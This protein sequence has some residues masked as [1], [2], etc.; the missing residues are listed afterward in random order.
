MPRSVLELFNEIKAETGSSQTARWIVAEAIS[1]PYYQALSLGL[2]VQD[3]SIAKAKGFVERLQ[4]GEPIQYV[5]GRWGFRDLELIVDSRA[6]IPRPE[7]EV[8]VEMAIRYLSRKALEHPRVLELGT[9]SGACAIAIATEVKGSYVLATDLSTEA[10]SLATTNLEAHKGRISGQVELLR[11]DW[12][13]AVD[14]AEQ[15]MIESGRFDL[16]LSNP[17]YINQVDYDHLD[18]VVRNW[19]PK[20]AL[21]SGK[22]GT[23]QLETILEKAPRYLN[24]GASVVLEMD[25]SQVEKVAEFARSVGYQCEIF[26]DLAERERGL[27]ATRPSIE[28]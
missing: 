19:E 21:L 3:A 23:E 17:P 16:I 28:E 15:A 12:F 8:V 7:T 20:S 13:S 1:T 27:V 18:P 6:L 4:R 2:E 24:K 22:A 26:R 25:P 11:A 14:P 5:L 9:G 10:L